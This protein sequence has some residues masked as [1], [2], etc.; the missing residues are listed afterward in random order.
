M[1]ETLTSRS[2]EEQENELEENIP[3]VGFLGYEP[4]FRVRR[5]RHH[6]VFPPSEHAVERY[7]NAAAVATHESSRAWAKVASGFV[8]ELA[9]GEEER[10]VE[11]GVAETS[12][13]KVEGWLDL[14][15]GWR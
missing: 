7:W 15:A 14:G 4:L 5:G 12:R 3:Q 9:S 8:L 6:P 10:P 13:R 2:R 1:I 11:D